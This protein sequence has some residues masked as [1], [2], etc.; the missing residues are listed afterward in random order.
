MT[1]RTAAGPVGTA[2]AALLLHT[3]SPPPLVGQEA[4]LDGVGVVV[5]DPS[6][7]ITVVEY[8]DFAC[9]ACAT[10]ALTTW[11]AVFRDYVETG[12]VQWRL[13]FFELGFRNSEKGARAGQ[14]AARQNRFWEMHDALYARRHEWVD[15]RKAHERLEAMA[16]DVGLNM[17]DYRRCFDDDDAED[18]R[19]AANRAA[20]EDGI[21]GTPTFF[22]NGFRV[23]GALPQAAFQAL[24]VPPS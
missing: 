1:V 19:K 22:I 17:E 16:A 18:Q 12:Q 3:G 13:V 21:R 11:P 2:L 6:A 4:D 5:G 8:A 24:L 15:E 14:C 10:F 9:G 23:Q 20:R 7:P